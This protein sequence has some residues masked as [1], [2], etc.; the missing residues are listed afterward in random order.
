MSFRHGPLRGIRI[1]DKADM[2][3]KQTEKQHQNE[4]DEFSLNGEG[5]IPTHILRQS[6]APQTAPNNKRMLSSSIQESRDFDD[7]PYCGS[8]PES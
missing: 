7:D 3:P 8:T 4:Q 2:P 5:L 6:Y 1:G